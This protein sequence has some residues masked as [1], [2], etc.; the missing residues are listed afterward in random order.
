MKRLLKQAHRYCYIFVVVFSFLLLYPLLYFY[1]RKEERF[2]VLNRLKGVFSFFTTAFAG[3]FFKYTRETEI[4]WSKPYVICPNHSSNLDIQAVSMFV[5]RNFAFMG[6]DDLLNNPVTGLF[7]RSVDIPVNRDS[8]IS[9]FR[10]FKR[11][12]EYLQKGYSVIIFPEGIIAEAY[13]PILQSFKNGAFRLAIEH[14]I[15]ILPVSI[16]DVWKIMWDDGVKFG[17]KPGLGT[18]YIHPP[19]ETKDLTLEDADLLREQVYDK[20]NSKLHAIK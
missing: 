20:I 10:A 7:F 8:K 4:D 5:K 6:K 1:S 13:P 14:K 2:P 16:T 9:A 11:A 15:A 18:V 3:I 12:G 17:T 19:I